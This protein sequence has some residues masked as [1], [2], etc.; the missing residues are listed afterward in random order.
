[1]YTKTE[2]INTI[3]VEFEGEIIYVAV[4]FSRAEKESILIHLECMY[5]IEMPNVL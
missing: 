5:D 1:M 3:I 4:F 2:L